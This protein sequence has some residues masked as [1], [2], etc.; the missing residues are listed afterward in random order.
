MSPEL[1]ALILR[2]LRLLTF[3]LTH[4]PEIQLELR[5]LNDSI[6]AMVNEGRNPSVE[7]NA[8]L[9]ARLDRAHN[10]LSVL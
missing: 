5:A 9:Q 7:E 6:A 4:A 1:A 2:Y 8:A 10:A 3:G